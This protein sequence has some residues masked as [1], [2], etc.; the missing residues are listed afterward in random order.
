MACV[1]SAV[2]LI[3]TLTFGNTSNSCKTMHWDSSRISYCM[4]WWYWPAD[5]SMFVHSLSC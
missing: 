1:K 4:V 2:Y 5:G 3:M